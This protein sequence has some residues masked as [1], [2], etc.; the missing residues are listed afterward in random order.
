MH[1]PSESR[2]GIGC[3][4]RL[5]RQ[6]CRRCPRQAWAWR[7]SAV[8]AA[9][10][11]GLTA[12]GPAPAQDTLLGNMMR[13]QK[14]WLWFSIVDGR[15]SLRLDPIGPHPPTTSHSA[16]GKETFKLRNEN[17]QPRLSY[18]RTTDKELLKI[19]VAGSGDDVHISRAP[20]G[21]SALPAVDFRQVPGE[22]VV[23][24]WG[25]AP[26]SRSSVPPICGGWRSREPKECRRHLLPAAGRAAARLEVG[27]R[28]DGDRS[29]AGG[30]GRRGGRRPTGPL[31]GPGPPTGRRQLR[32]ARGGRPGVAGRR[33]RRCWPTCGIWTSAGWM[34]SSGSASAGFWRPR[35]RRTETIRPSRPRPRWPPTRPSGWRLLGRPELATRQA[36]AGQLAS[37]LG[38]PVGVDPAAEPETQ[39]DKREQLRRRIEEK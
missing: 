16:A 27:R 8:I 33:P 39:K 38:G 37:L 7:R 15:M 24:S 10:L 12:A 13:A 5:T 11:L 22:P 20:Q 21:K 19:E 30:G 29:E 35:P 26:G 32:P 9:M 17:G 23:S 1:L 14:D 18:E 31:G 3:R 25:P 4:V 28:G 6:R 34:P 36:A 2:R